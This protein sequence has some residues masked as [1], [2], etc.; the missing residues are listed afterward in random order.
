MFLVLFTGG[1]NQQLPKGLTAESLQQNQVSY[2]DD[3]LQRIREIRGK[4]PKK[5]RDWVLAKKERRRRQGKEVREDTKYTARK[6]S[7]R[8]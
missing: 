8:F 1:T 7:G 4:P 2:A 3:K 5:S 6:R